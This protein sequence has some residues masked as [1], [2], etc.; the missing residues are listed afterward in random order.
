MKTISIHSAPAVRN[1]STF[2]SRV[3]LIDAVTSSAM[4]LLLVG[5]AG[6]LTPLLGLPIDLLRG[7]GAVLLPFAAGLIALSLRP[8]PPAA[9]VCTVVALNALWT[10]ASLLLLLVPG[11]IE[12][13][14]FGKAFIFLQ[15]AVVGLFA[16]LE[17]LGWRRLGSSGV[18]N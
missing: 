13:T 12:P 1:A 2:L 15:A 11:S 8:S 9:G 17:Y 7:S 6:W 10:V 16:A 3:L 18:R 5:A 4:G 14:A